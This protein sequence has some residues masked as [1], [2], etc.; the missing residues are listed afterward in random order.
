MIRNF[1]Y[2]FLVLTLP[3]VK[4]KYSLSIQQYFSHLIILFVL[5]PQSILFFVSSSE[6]Q[7]LRKIETIC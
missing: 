1:F 3:V 7:N 4:M 5:K 6:C 2:I